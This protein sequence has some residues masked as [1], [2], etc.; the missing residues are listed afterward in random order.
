ME[1]M[2]RG[3]KTDDAGLH[4]RCVECVME[5]E[6]EVGSSVRAPW[7]GLGKAWLW[8]GRRREQ[9]RPE[10]GWIWREPPYH[11]Q[12]PPGYGIAWMAY[13][14]KSFLNGLEVDENGLMIFYNQDDR[15][16]N[17]LSNLANATNL[18][19]TVVEKEP[20]FFWMW[21][22]SSLSW[23]TSLHCHFGAKT[24]EWHLAFSF[25]S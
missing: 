24:W 17:G 11:A 18:A 8:C 15:G 13:Y 22:L 12:F 9:C 20:N 5:S 23:A 16:L 6:R 3:K 1:G 2:Q 19:N 4:P 21:N 25:I 14:I 10:S 7:C